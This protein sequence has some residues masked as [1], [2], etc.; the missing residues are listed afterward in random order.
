MIRAARPYYSVATVHSSPNRYVLPRIVVT[1]VFVSVQIVEVVTISPS[2]N[3]GWLYIWPHTRYWSITISGALYCDIPDDADMSTT[4]DQFSRVGASPISIDSSTAR[5]AGF[6]S[7]EATASDCTAE[8]PLVDSRSSSLCS[9]S[10]QRALSASRRLRLRSCF[11][12][13]FFC[14]FE[15]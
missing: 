12:R 1:W 14:A 13:F 9:C 6:S 15:R 11:W 7:T 5:D 3:L 10:W 8:G 2:G 4:I